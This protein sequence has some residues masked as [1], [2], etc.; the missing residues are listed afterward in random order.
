[1]KRLITL[2]LLSAFAVTLFSPT[3][4]ALQ[5]DWRQ[6]PPESVIRDTQGARPDGEEGGWN[7][8][9]SSPGAEPSSPLLGG[10]WIVFITVEV[11]EYLIKSTSFESED[12]RSGQTQFSRPTHSR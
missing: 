3:V 5:W 7:V 9:T 6:P 4:V 2:L 8:P 1:M 10:G 12:S 11:T